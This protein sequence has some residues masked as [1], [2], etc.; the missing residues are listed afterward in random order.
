MT[1][2]NIQQNGAAIASG[3]GVE[4][5]MKLYRNVNAIAQAL[6]VEVIRAQAVEADRLEAEKSLLVSEV[7]KANN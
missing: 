3:P 7:A 2:P 6:H 4:F 1:T 5:W